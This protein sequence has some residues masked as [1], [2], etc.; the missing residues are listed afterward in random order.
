MSKK[1]RVTSFV[2]T[3]NV[4]LC[5]YSNSASYDD[6]NSANYDDSDSELCEQE[7]IDSGIVS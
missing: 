6:S 3:I 5:L 7:K 2:K 1:L 4:I